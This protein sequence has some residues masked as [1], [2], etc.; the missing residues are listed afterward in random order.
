VDPRRLDQAQRIIRGVA[1]RHADH[2]TGS[3]NSRE[4]L[5]QHALAAVI[6][7]A[8]RHDPCRSPWTAY[9]AVTARRAII[10]HLRRH[11]PGWRTRH[12]HHPVTV[13]G[14]PPTELPAAC[15]LAEHATARVLARDLLATLDQR[16]RDVILARVIGDV[17][18]RHVA[19]SLGVNESRASQITH[20]ALHRM[21]T[22]A[23]RRP[24]A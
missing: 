12:G 21:R 19:A 22:H 4:D 14:E 3:L 23:S 5:E 1:R 10:D 17:P 20:A 24:A 16:E 7:A 8:P 2:H 6:A 18:V 9:V 15:D 13:T 11:N